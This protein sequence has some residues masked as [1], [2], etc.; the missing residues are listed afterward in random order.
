MMAHRT[1]FAL[2]SVISTQ[3][4]I[5]V[6]PISRKRNTWTPQEY[7]WC[8]THPGQCN[9]YNNASYRKFLV[10]GTTRLQH[11]PLLARPRECSLPS[12]LGQGRR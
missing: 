1:G 3:H 6:Q 5:K 10:N 2:I 12:W 7:T 11:F 4:S 8:Q 9:M